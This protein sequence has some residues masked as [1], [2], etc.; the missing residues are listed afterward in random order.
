MAAII[1]ALVVLH[2]LMTIPVALV[3]LREDAR[4][5]DWRVQAQAL[6]LDREWRRIIRG[7]E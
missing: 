3:I 7:R 1:C 2:V 6:G 4:R 5:D